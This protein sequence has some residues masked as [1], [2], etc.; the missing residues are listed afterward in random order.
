M[1]L[2]CVNSI[3]LNT[4]AAF[5]SKLVLNAGNNSGNTGVLIPK[6]NI[7]RTCDVEVVPTGNKATNFPSH[8]SIDLDHK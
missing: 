2:R 4:D 5:L 7:R 3:P 8:T 6:R 1:L